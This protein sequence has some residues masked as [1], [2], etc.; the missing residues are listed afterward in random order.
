MISAGGTGGGVYPALAVAGAVRKLYPQA[1]LYFVGAR[2]DMARGL[3]EQSD[4]HFDGYHEVFAGPVAGIPLTGQIVSAIKIAVGV[5]QSLVLGLRLRPEVLF[6]TGGWVGVPAALACWLLRCPIVIYVP[7]IEPGMMLKVI[8][9]RFARVIAA[10]TDATAAY[11][12]GKRVEVTGYPLR[13][14][15]LEADR[16]RGIEALKLDPQRRTLLVF[17][18]SRGSRSINSTISAIAPALLEDGCQIV[19]ISGRLDWPQVEQAHAAMTPE[20]RAHYQVHPFL[21][22]IGLAFAA[23]DL[24]ISRAGAATL[25]EYPQLGLPAILVPYPHAWRYQKVNADFL[26]E[27]GAAVRLDDER[28]ADELL[29]LVRELL[30]DEERLA[31]MRRASEALRQPDGADNIARLLART[32]G[33]PAG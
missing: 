8:G 7:D 2:G 4:V 10:T 5:V 6:L 1:K 30:A 13:R 31:A 23:A 19:H 20:Q 17:G 22:D 32:A 12:P 16:A 3:V 25:A 9:R 14:E 24:V 33:H 21:P 18:G 29:P 28:L 27:R 15:I 11:Y 26:V